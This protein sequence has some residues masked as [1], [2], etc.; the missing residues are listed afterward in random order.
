MW[1][2]RREGR[3]AWMPGPAR[4]AV[5]GFQGSVFLLDD[6][7]LHLGLHFRVQADRHGKD[8]KRLERLIELDLT[9]V[10]LEVETLLLQAVRN[11]LRSDRPEQLRLLARTRVEG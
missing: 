7:D 4:C 8:A 10:D 3:T 9:A 1:M 5:P 6:P 11:V 2:Q